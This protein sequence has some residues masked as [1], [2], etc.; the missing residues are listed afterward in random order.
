M[1]KYTKII[2]ASAALV[3]VLALC[4]GIF[5]CKKND[6]ADSDNGNNQDNNSQVGGND[7]IPDIEIGDGTEN[8]DGTVDI[9]INLGDLVGGNDKDDGIDP[10]DGKITYEEYWS[11]S[12]EER[13]EYFNSFASADE[14]F[15]WYNQIQDE[16]NNKNKQ[17]SP[18][19]GEDG[20]IDLGGN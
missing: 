14:F 3:V 13:E 18:L 8:D 12:A 9:E 5:A 10:D 17:D 2:I 19:I 16:Y 7:Q 15:V 4:L 11:W 20:S 1:N 6:S